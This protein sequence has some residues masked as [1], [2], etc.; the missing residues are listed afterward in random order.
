VKILPSF[1]NL[2]LDFRKSTMEFQ[3]TFTTFGNLTQF[4]EERDSS[5]TNNQFSFGN[6]NNQLSLSIDT[7]T[8]PQP[9]LPPLPRMNPEDL[10][11]R[12]SKFKE[13]LMQIGF[14]EGHAANA[15]NRACSFLF[16]CRAA[17]T[18]PP[19]WIVDHHVVEWTHHGTLCCAGEHCKNNFKAT[20][21]FCSHV[22]A[23]A[24]FEGLDIFQLTHHSSGIY[25][26][27]LKIL[28][29]VFLLNNNIIRGR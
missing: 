17:N 19:Q 3:S 12:F 25:T 16:S 15:L 23:V 5:S 2:N 21:G 11:V 22:L 29:L 10:H 27:I 18:D 1:Q 14:H 24:L 9:L 8:L 6:I 20:L 7:D 26:N 28:L 4:T 13:A